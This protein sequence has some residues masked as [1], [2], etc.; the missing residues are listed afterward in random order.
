MGNRLSSR[1]TPNKVAV[2]ISCAAAFLWSGSRAFATSIALPSEGSVA[3]VGAFD[4]ADAGSTA[5]RNRYTKTGYHGLANTASP[6]VAAGPSRAPATGGPG[7]SPDAAGQENLFHVLADGQLV[8]ALA[9]QGMMSPEALEPAPEGLAQ[10]PGAYKS[11]SRAVNAGGASTPD[12]P[13]DPQAALVFQ[14]PEPITSLGPAVVVV[15]VGPAE[16][17][18][19]LH[20]NASD[21]ATPGTSAPFAGNILTND[22]P[23]NDAP[24]NGPAP[25]GG[26]SIGVVANGV[27]AVPEPASLLLLG[28]GLV[29]AGA[30]RWKRP[31]HPHCGTPRSTTRCAAARR[32]PSAES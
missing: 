22:V 17:G 14:I 26:L 21:P 31:S 27:A 10:A 18:G 6:A 9:T 20:W 3:T 8:E 11:A 4:V 23:I 12:G 25:G 16:D 24:G 30:R 29:I 7:L 13:G 28:G 15:D 32:S 19:G 1:S 2:V 5:A